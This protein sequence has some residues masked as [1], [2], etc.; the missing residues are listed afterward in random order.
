M[1]PAQDKPAKLGNKDGEARAATFANKP[2]SKPKSQWARVL[3][4]AGVTDSSFHVIRHTFASQVMADDHGIY[5]LSKMLGH[6]R[7]STTERYAH[8]AK[9]AGAPAAEDVSKRY[10]VQPKQPAKRGSK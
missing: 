6:A 9:N 5:T 10:G 8:L 1:F 7:V 2:M 4:R 3:K